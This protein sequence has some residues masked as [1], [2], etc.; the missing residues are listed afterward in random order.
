MKPMELVLLALPSATAVKLQVFAQL[1]L[2]LK[3]DLIKTVNAQLVS[4]MM[5][6][7]HA[8]PATH[9]ARLVPTLLHALH[10]SLKTTE[11]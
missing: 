11:P 6:L 9:S 10:A 3:G 1:A 5:A 2:I 8:R 4:L 7:P